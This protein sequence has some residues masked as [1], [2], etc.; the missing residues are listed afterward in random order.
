[1]F[2]NVRKSSVIQN[3]TADCLYAV[4]LMLEEE[5][6]ADETCKHLQLDK[7]KPDNSEWEK[8]IE[9]IRKRSDEKVK[10][11]IVGKYVKL[12]DSYISVMESLYHAGFA[13]HVKVKVHLIDSETINNENVVRKLKGIDGVVVP[14]G[15]GNR[16]IEGKITAIKY[17]RENKIPFFGICL[18]MQCAVI[19]FSRNVANLEDANSEEFEPKAKDNVIYLMKE[20][21]DFRSMD[22][23]HRSESSEKGGTMRLGSYPC[24][25]Y[26]DT[27]AHDAYSSDS[28]EERHRHRYEFNNEYLSAMEAAGMKASGRNP[29]T[30]L[31]EIVEIPS[32]PFFIGVQFH[33]ESI[34]TPDGMAMIANWLNHKSDKR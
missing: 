8:M 6:L 3:K 22:I 28:I 11:A 7:C 24:K 31:V 2:C 18:G 27:N 30:G 26:P 20:W 34:L 33:P 25:L 17:A 29:E 19:E 5:G 15:F 32:H 10:I 4:P 21:F 1:M 12:E 23:Q 14:G 9:N 16:G 13:N